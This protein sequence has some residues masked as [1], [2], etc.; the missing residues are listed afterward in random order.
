MTNFRQLYQFSQLCV[1]RPQGCKNRKGRLFWL[2]LSIRSNPACPLKLHI[3]SY[4]IPIYNKDNSDGVLSRIVTTI[5]PLPHP[6]KKR[7][8]LASPRFIFLLI[9]FCTG[10]IFTFKVFAA[11][12]IG[13]PIFQSRL[14]TVPIE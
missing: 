1:L 12:F 8:C 2:E 13:I 3:A 9:H 11:F 6:V 4:G 10:F 14:Y 5:S 7:G